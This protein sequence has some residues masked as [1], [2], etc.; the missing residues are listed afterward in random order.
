MLKD[1]ILNA[2]I[3]M[4][5]K[6]KQLAGEGKT[7]INTKKNKTLF[8]KAIDDS[9]EKEVLNFL[10]K[11]IDVNFLM[12]DNKTFIYPIGAA[13]NAQIFSQNIMDMLIDYGAKDLLSKKSLDLGWRSDFLSKIKN[14]L[15]LNEQE[16]AK[17]KV[18][19]VVKIIG[20]S[21]AHVIKNRFPIFNFFQTLK[22]KELLD[23][24][25]LK[26]FMDELDSSVI[27]FL[28]KNL[29]ICWSPETDFL[30]NYYVMPTIENAHKIS[31]S[32]KLVEGSEKSKLQNGEFK[33]ATNTVGLNVT[34]GVGINSENKIDE[35][36]VYSSFYVP[37]VSSDGVQLDSTINATFAST[38]KEV[39]TSKGNNVPGDKTPEEKNLKE[40]LKDYLVCVFDEKMLSLLIYCYSLLNEIEENEYRKLLSFNGKDSK[41]GSD[42]KEQGAGYKEQDDGSLKK[43]FVDGFLL[44][45]FWHKTFD[46]DSINCMKMLCEKNL[47]PK[48]DMLYFSLH[49]FFVNNYYNEFGAPVGYLRKLSTIY[50]KN[51][52]GYEW[53]IPKKKENFIMNEFDESASLLCAALLKSSVQC[54]EILMNVEPLRQKMQASSKE[55]SFLVYSQDLLKT[56]K[57]LKKSDY[58]LNL[59]K[60]INGVNPLHQ[61][62]RTESAKTVVQEVLKMNK[63]W[64]FGRTD[65]G[66]TPVDMLSETDRVS[67]KVMIDD[68]VLRSEVGRTGKRPGISVRG[69]KSL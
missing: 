11:G 52:G 5:V 9:N 33:E 23:N 12:Q 16:L 45:E 58:D 63:Q 22:V 69:Q 1:L 42:I 19:D 41:S 59:L 24:K 38:K 15:N 21:N 57:M 3:E 64:V 66:K 46:T 28:L 31:F 29:S 34:K 37:I 36:V 44:N 47:L 13:I 55:N 30:F 25:K 65:S 7:N 62:I 54:S 4:E 32:T 17:V 27:D 48:D 49:N 14:E 53:V 67:F 56:L 26:N 6:N 40:I 60:D 51:Y 68:I 39:L 10:R 50:G 35:K 61:V 2:A 18:K 20:D 43:D 8:I